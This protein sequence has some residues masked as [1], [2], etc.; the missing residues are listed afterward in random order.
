MKLFSMLPAVVVAAS[1]ATI[2]LVPGEVRAQKG[3][4]LCGWVT[5]WSPVHIGLLYEV[6][7][8][9]DSHRKQ[10]RKAIAQM[11]EM[12]KNDPNLSR[13]QW[14]KIDRKPCE[15]VGK[16]GLAYTS[17][18][19]ERRYDI[20]EMMEAKKAYKVEKRDNETTFTKL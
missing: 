1:V 8:A 12:I 20:C 13:W 5:T 19:G 4:R 17:D 16:M 15:D 2:A 6:R 9:D 3:S 10:C 14:T 11:E 7:R 18:K